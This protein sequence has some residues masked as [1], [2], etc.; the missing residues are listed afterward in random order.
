MVPAGQEEEAGGWSF[1]AN[2]GKGSVKPY[3]KN[4]QKQ[5]D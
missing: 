2:M 4:K 3:L 1:Q 5:K